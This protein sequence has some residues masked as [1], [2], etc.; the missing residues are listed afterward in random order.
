MAAKSKSGRPKRRRGKWTELRCPHC[1]KW[2]QIRATP[3]YP[4]NRS[5]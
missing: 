4:S 3:Y 2:I 5:G 1:K